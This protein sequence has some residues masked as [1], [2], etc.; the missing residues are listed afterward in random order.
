MQHSRSALV[1]L[2]LGYRSDWLSELQTSNGQYPHVITVVF[3]TRQFNNACRLHD[4]LRT[5]QNYFTVHSNMTHDIIKDAFFEA[6]RIV[7]K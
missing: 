4:K 3:L 7:Q 2:N 1:F 6:I 5:T